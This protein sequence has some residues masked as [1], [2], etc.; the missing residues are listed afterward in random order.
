MALSKLYHLTWVT[1][2]HMGQFNDD[3]NCLAQRQLRQSY[4]RIQV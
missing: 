3:G 1:V 4:T 2:G